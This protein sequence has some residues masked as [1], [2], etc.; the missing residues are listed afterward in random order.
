METLE[1]RINEL[2]SLER[3]RLRIESQLKSSLEEK[4]LLLKEIHHRVKNNMAVISS[5]LNLQSAHFSDK[6]VRD[7]FAD[8]RGRI[9]SMALVHEQLYKSENLAKIY[10]TLYINEL[11][12][13]IAQSGEFD[14]SGI[15]ME[16]TTDAIYLGIDSAVPCG[17]LINELLT[18]AFKYAFPH[19]REG[20]IKL[21]MKDLGD[22]LYCLEVS[23]NGVGLPEDVNLNE[24]KTFGLQLVKLLTEQL[25]GSIEVDRTNGTRFTIT[26]KSIRL[27]N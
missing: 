8:T 1:R 6:A 26:F 7:A 13:R 21:S 9:R 22:N 10:F 17:M 12:A 14:S 3:E 15:D 20:I 23:D 27:S 24:P 11:A 4:E 25:N 5:L 2:E 18:N 16:I 19:H